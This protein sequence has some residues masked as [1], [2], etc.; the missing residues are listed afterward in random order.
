MSPY[1]PRLVFFIALV[2][3]SHPQALSAQT[4]TTTNLSLLSGGAPVTTV[5]A[6]TM[7][8]M[9][10]TVTGGTSP[11][12]TG[13][14]Y[15]CDSVVKNCMIMPTATAQVVNGSAIFKTVLATGSYSFTAMYVPAA[16]FGAST[17]SAVTL[18]V[19]A[20]AAPTLSQSMTASYSG[21]RYD[22]DASLS[23]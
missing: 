11:I 9:S 2:L 12:T 6:G 1:F 17:S 14:I 4:A 13:T 10:A 16:G 23:A 22:F 7:V 21:G 18:T 20:S 5:T 3:V 15:F 8:T 19:P